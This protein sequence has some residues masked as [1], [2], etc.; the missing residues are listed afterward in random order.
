ME[1]YVLEELSVS[2]I[3]TANPLKD[4]FPVPKFICPL[5]RL[6]RRDSSTENS[7]QTENCLKFIL[8]AKIMRSFSANILKPYLF[9][10]TWPDKWSSLIFPSDHR[11]QFILDG[12]LSDGIPP[13]TNMKLRL[14]TQF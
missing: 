8:D 11:P 9:I 4:E 2:S 6:N 10:A 7:S 12:F 14:F 1:I 3:N 5:F 13:L